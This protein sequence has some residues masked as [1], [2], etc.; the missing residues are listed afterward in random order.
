MGVLD[1]VIV[2]LLGISLIRGLSK[3][4]ISQ[5]IGVAALILGAWAAMLFNK[6]V[7]AW[8][9]TLT[10]TLDPSVLNTISYIVIFI[11][12]MVILGF[13]GK[14]LNGC[15]KLVM[16]G[17]LNRLLGAVLAVA[18]CLL[19]LGLIAILFDSLYGTWASVQGITEKPSAISDSVL[20]EPIHSFGNWIFPY[21]KKLTV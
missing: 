10:D 18:G 9:A 1:I 4:L 12:T 20:Y 15:V 19:I 7:G 2:V 8:L 5:V 21:L 6:P 11:V 13:A 16:L 17:W 3:G 14:F